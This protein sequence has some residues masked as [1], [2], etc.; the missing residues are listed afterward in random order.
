MARN[1]TPEFAA[2]APV[3]G[4]S[5]GEFSYVASRSWCSWNSLYGGA[6]LA[7]LALAMEQEAGRPLLSASAQYQGAVREG[8]ALALGVRISAGRTV[9]HA[10]ATGIL[11]GK[12]VV[13]ASG[14][15]GEAGPATQVRAAFPAGARGPLQSPPRVS[16]NPARGTLYDT[17]QVRIESV[18][19]PQVRF[20]ARCPAAAG[21]PLSAA[22]LAVLADHPPPA[23]VLVLGGDA[24]GVSLDTTLQIVDQSRRRDA[25]DWYLVA[26]GFE[27]VQQPFLFASAQ[28][29]AEDGTLVG[30]SAQSMLVRHGSPKAAT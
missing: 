19:P 26:V 11:A 3:P 2:L 7:A 14:V 30:L 6:L 10:S 20:W 22:M 24:F 23:V 13:S 25:G 12:T 18:A 9:A 17:L 15:L 4:P 5:P 27:A 8:D 21:Q 28:I 1:M 29:W 16:L